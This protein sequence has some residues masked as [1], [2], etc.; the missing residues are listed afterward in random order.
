MAT[1]GSRECRLRQGR[2]SRHRGQT[3]SFRFSQQTP[4][5]SGAFCHFA[6]AQDCPRKRWTRTIS[7]RKMRHRGFA[8]GASRCIA[9]PV[10]WRVTM[11]PGKSRFLRLVT[12]CAVLLLMAQAPEA[13]SQTSQESPVAENAQRASSDATQA[14][15]SNAEQQAANASGAAQGASGPSAGS[16]Q[17]EPS[18]A[19]GTQ[20]GGAQ[21]NSG[22]AQGNPAKPVGT[23]A[24]PAVNA[25]GVAGSRPTGAVIAPAKQR[26][27]RT[28]LIRVGVVVGACVAVGIVAALSH[29]SPSQPR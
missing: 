29:S 24:A 4:M 28:I 18:A 17:Q 7:F 8:A 14:D 5:R 23:A 20:S 21:S 13:T 19:S 26:R 25:T 3:G 1:Y 11:R 16:A 10:A 2:R 22:Q 9:R 27:V 12:G 15:N 6:R